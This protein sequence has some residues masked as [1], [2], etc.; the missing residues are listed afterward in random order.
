MAQFAAWGDS[1][2]DD[3]PAAA[4]YVTTDQYKTSKRLIAEYDAALSVAGTEPPAPTVEDLQAVIERDRT[5]VCDAINGLKKV[6]RE[7]EWLGEG[8]GPYEWDDD[9]WHDEF[10]ATAAE[11]REAL[12]PLE[13]IAANLS[14]S[15]TTHEAVQKAREIPTDKTDDFEA[16]QDA[17][18]QGSERC[19]VCHGSEKVPLYTW[20]TNGCRGTFHWIDAAAPVSEKN[21]SGPSAFVSDVNIPDGPSCSAC[22]VAMV[23][24]GVCDGSI[25]HQTYGI[26]THPLGIVCGDWHPVEFRC[27]SCGATTGLTDAKGTEP[28]APANPLVCDDC[29]HEGCDCGPFDAINRELANLRN[30]AN[31]KEVELKAAQERIRELE[32]RQKGPSAETSAAYAAH[33]RDAYRDGCECA[34]CVLVRE[35]EARQSSAAPDLFEMASGEGL[36]STHTGGPH[37]IERACRNWKPVMAA[38]V[39]SPIPAKEEGKKE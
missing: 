19:P 9:R 1:W 39:P 31:R 12:K 15:P 8:R 35:L 28:L 27:P 14:N 34:M 22:G 13:K 10:N 25:C 24:V 21:V 36:C 11:I 17:G 3:V 2:R 37:R 20:P 6:I 16:R 18:R 4:A 23:K 33:V 7:R 30:W 32:A 5:N 26:G 38:P 29:G